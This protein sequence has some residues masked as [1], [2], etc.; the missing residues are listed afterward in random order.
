MCR[1]V[2]AF[3]NISSSRGLSSIF[4]RC[5]GEFFPSPRFLADRCGDRREI[6]S[7]LYTGPMK[8]VSLA[9]REPRGRGEEARGRLS[10]VH[11]LYIRVSWRTESLAQSSLYPIIYGRT[12]SSDYGRADMPLIRPGQ[13]Y[14]RAHSNI[15][16][17]LMRAR[18]RASERATGRVC[19]ERDTWHSEHEK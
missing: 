16:P 18:A 19:I 12:M 4:R 17:G 15:K 7:A 5:D 13:T 9:S 2:R 10:W 3:I 1:A 6:R 11:Y 14:L 8:H